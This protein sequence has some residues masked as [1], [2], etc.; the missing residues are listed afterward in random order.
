M[1]KIEKL[2]R[3]I[4]EKERILLKETIKSLVTGEIKGM[5][6]VKIKDTDFFRI[7]K[8]KFRIIFHYNNDN[9]IID[10]VKLRNE[11]TYK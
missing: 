2:L 3:K 5:N 6:I 10:S 1:D 7:K 11:N 9:V 8:G 4:C